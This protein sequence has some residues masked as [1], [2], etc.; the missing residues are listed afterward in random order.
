MVD[1]SAV[2][3]CIS[4]HCVSHAAGPVVVTRNRA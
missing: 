3:G 2:L 1:I 4:L